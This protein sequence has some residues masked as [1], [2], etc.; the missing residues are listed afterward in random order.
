MA[1]RQAVAMVTAVSFMFA[2]GIPNLYAAD[3]HSVTSAQL[4]QAVQSAH[5]KVAASR[6]GMNEVLARADVQRQL[7]LLGLA[8]EKVRA[9]VSLLSDTEIVRLHQ[10]VMSAELQQARNGLSTGAIVGIVIVGVAGIILFNVLMYNYLK[11]KSPY[12][13]Y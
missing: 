10:Q 7:R 11:E 13:Y 5:A 9:Q 8:P 12:Y 3:R 6:K 4:H 1:F 2:I